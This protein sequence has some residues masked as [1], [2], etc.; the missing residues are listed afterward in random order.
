MSTDNVVEIS[1][2]K[3]SLR[4]PLALFRGN[5]FAYAL[6]RRK[7]TI[8][9]AYIIAQKYFENTCPFL[10]ECNLVRKLQREGER[11]G[12][13]RRFDSLLEISWNIMNNFVI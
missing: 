10:R 3:D 4:L 2:L 7:L 1:S 13:L 6:C 11:G 8:F 12:E 9:D 5:R